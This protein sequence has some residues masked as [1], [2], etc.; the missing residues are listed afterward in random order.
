ME[1]EVFKKEVLEGLQKICGD[2]VQIGLEKILKN[3]GK[4]YDGIRIFVDE[5]D[6]RVCPA[7]PL[8]NFYGAYCEGDMSIAGCARAIYEMNEEYREMGGVSEMLQ[9]IMDWEQV[10]ESIYP[11]LLSTEDNRE[12][13]EK[14]VS[15]PML[16]LSVAYIYRKEI[17]GRC[18]SVK[19]NYQMLEAYGISA[20]ELHRHALENLENDGYCF[21]DIRSFVVEKVYGDFY[22]ADQQGDEQTEDF[23]I[24]TNGSMYY[25]AA[26]ILN[27]KQVRKFADARDFYILPASIHETIFVPVD[28]K[29]SVDF[30]RG[31][32]KLVNEE[33]LDI[34][35]KL[36][37]HVYFYDAGADEIK[38]CA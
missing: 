9:K 28:G 17:D 22:E 32:V 2:E 8:Q 38:I 35:D 5:S 16:D 7:I 36:S 3:N 1:Y 34:E 14:V 25:G 11:I 21:R 19:I 12:L 24:Y 27:R 31:I 33:E 18:A 10:K 37:D 4:H 29:K 15:I 13:F 23:Y 26:G 6:R 20:E 30:Y